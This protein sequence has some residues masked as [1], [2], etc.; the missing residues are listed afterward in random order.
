MKNELVEVETT[1]E[2]MYSHFGGGVIG[3]MSAVPPGV[4]VETPTGELTPVNGVIRKEVEDIL[5]IE[6]EDGRT[7]ECSPGHL[8]QDEK[9][10][11]IRAEEATRIMTM[12]GPRKV[13]NREVVAR[14]NTYD[15]SVDPPYWYVSPNGIIHHNTFFAL[16]IVKE[17][18]EKYPGSAVMYY[19]TES[20]ITRDMVAAR[21]I[22]PDRVIVGEP[23]TLQDFRTKAITFLD[24]YGSTPKDRRP[25]LMV[26]LDSL[27]MLSSLKEMEDTTAGKDTRDMTKSQLVRGV[28][29]VLR[30]KLAKLHVPMIVTG[31]TYASIGCMIGETLVRMPGGYAVPISEIEVGDEVETL[32][33]PK[34]VVDTYRYDD[35]EVFELEMDDGSVITVTARHR[36]L[37]Q[38]LVWKTV[39]ELGEGD[40]IVGLETLPD[41]IDVA[42]WDSRLSGGLPEAV[43]PHS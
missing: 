40:T 4:F 9:G 18:L 28:F 27:G 37:T 12:T 7:F 16:G 2:N 26:V 39:G 30:L 8:F 10:K 19:D 17:F 34:L 24:R 6:L 43:I 15:V 36:F 41:G 38:D 42:G 13:V 31:H 22:D 25:P 29:R 21:G 1:Y 14:E 5:R 32:V 35:S 23:Q 33:G 20:A 3:E 11:E